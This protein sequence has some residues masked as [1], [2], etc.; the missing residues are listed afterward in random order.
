MAITARQRKIGFAGAA[1]VSAAAV[2]GLL[3]GLGPHYLPQAGAGVLAAI[4]LMGVFLATVP[5]WRRL[6]DMQ[7][8]SRLV[9]W[10]WGGGFGSGLGLLLA[11]VLA[12]VRSPLFEGAALVW[13]LQF[14]GYA[15][16][17]FRW[18]LAHRSAAA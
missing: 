6:D 14:L 17:R 15:V 4:V 3:I 16:A 9:S 13:L 1:A 10:Y 11:L 12:G 8:D 7:R 5:R 2:G 18:W